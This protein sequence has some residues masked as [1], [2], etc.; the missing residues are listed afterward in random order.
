M[1]QAQGAA[2]VWEK[3]PT[4]P[5]RREDFRKTVIPELSLEKEVGIHYMGEAIRYVFRVEW[6]VRRLRGVRL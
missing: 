5:E 4:S 2:G 1:E 3:C 6:P